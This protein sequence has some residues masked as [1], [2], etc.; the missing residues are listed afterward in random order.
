[1]TRSN[2]CKYSLTD[3]HTHILSEFDDGADSLETALKMLRVQR[4]M[5]VDRVALTSHFYPLSEDL[6][7]YLDRRQQAYTTLLS[8]WDKDTMPDLRLGAEVRYSP[9]LI[10]VDLRTLT[11]GAGDYLLLELPNFVMPAYLEQMIDMMLMQGVFPILAHVERCEYFRYEPNLLQRL[12]CMGALAQIS[13]KALKNKYD[14]RF[15]ESCL[16]N[17]LAQIV[18]S[19][20][21]DLSNREPCLGS[22]ALKMHR[23]LILRAEKFACAVWENKPH[24]TFTI[25]SIK[26]SL[27]GYH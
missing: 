27:W 4:K 13:A 21:H 11:I 8:G 1:M 17:G 26:K 23:E 3:L 22:V 25:S 10:D 18:A 14:R 24:P 15:A 12:I 20:A 7:T 19:D 6:E 16:K 9:Q 2:S 5:G